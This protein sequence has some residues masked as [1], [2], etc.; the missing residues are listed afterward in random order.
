MSI[1]FN[2]EE[3]DA[4]K[5]DQVPVTAGKTPL[6]EAFA[7]NL[8]KVSQPMDRSF[9]RSDFMMGVTGILS[10]SLLALQLIPGLP[11]NVALKPSDLHL[12]LGF[13]QKFVAFSSFFIYH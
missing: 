1:L 11:N 7:V 10:V 9:L 6:I 12:F 8:K 3:N 5:A 4:P 13:L 2:T